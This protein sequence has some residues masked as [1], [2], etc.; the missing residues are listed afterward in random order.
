MTLNAESDVEAGAGAPED[1]TTDAVAPEAVEA[2]AQPETDG[3][4]APSAEA[5]D[6]RTP[7]EIAREEFL[8]KYGEPE[9]AP[10]E[11]EKPASKE[12]AE[13]SGERQEDAP[14]AGKVRLT[15]EELKALPPKAQQRIGQLSSELR[16]AKKA[17]AEVEDYRADREAMT[18]LRAFTEEA[19]L[20]GQDMARTLGMA[21]DFT[22]GRFKD[23]LD[24]VMPLVT[25]AQQA[26]GLAVAPDLQSLIDN[27]EMTPEAAKR[28]TQAEQA[29]KLAETTAARERQAREAGDQESAR[30][31]HLTALTNAVRQTEIALRAEDPDYAL[32][33]PAIQAQF[34]AFL[35][36]GAIPKDAKDAEALIRE[37]HQGVVIAKPAPLQPTAPHPTASTVT[38]PLPPPRNTLEAITRAAETMQQPR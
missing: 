14:A 27:G 23:F 9:P 18:R 36:R 1:V 26:L 15:D 12:A 35:R 19:G 8:K 37:I 2:G 10:A 25:T 28:L 24:T 29:R 21:R 38:R 4:S 16:D 17:A 11:P 13:E 20:S 5:A 32:K 7:G 31:A 22:A 34:G 3:G 30:A 33:E 6:T